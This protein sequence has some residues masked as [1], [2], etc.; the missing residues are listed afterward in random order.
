MT[1]L[2]F[3]LLSYVNGWFIRIRNHQ[4]VHIDPGLRPHVTKEMSRNQTIIF[5][6]LVGIE[7]G[8]LG[9]YVSVHFLIQ[10]L[11]RPPQIF[12]I[13]LECV[14]LVFMQPVGSSIRKIYLKQN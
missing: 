12:D 13:V 10:G 14:L 5:L 2:F 6:E 1:N 8:Q 3:H 11:Q 9:S 4:R 7:I